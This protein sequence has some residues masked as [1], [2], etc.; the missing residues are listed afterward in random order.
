VIGR[1]PEESHGKIF[2]HLVFQIKKP[3]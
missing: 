2:E 3:A 1:R